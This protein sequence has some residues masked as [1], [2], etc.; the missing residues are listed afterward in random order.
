MRIGSSRA[1]LV[2]V[3][4]LS[5]LVAG[6]SCASDGSTE[7]PPAG[8]SLPPAQGSDDEESEAEEP[9]GELGASRDNPIPTGQTGDAA[10]WTIEVIGYTANANAAVA[11]ENQFNEK[12]PAGSQYVMVTLRTTFNGSGSSDPFFDLTWSVIGGDGTTY[13]DNSALLPKDLANVD[14]VPNGASAEGNISFVVEKS[15]VDT[16]VLYIEGTTESFDTE[17]VFFALR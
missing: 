12:P 7:D 11:R 5:A 9:T 1:V 6:V 10:D 3:I 8:S 15:A 13:Q 2:V 16:I 4:A 17:G 14:N